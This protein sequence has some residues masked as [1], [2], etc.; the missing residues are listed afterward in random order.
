[1]GGVS[2]DRAADYYDATRA[3]PVDLQEELA[4]ILAAEL[5]GRGPCLEI[6]VG[7]GRIALPLHDRGLAL[8]GIDIAPA[9]L[10][11]LVTNAGDR[12]PFPL[13]LADATQLPLEGSSFGAVMA[14]HVLHLIPEWPLAVDEALRVLRPRGV[15]LV[16][17]GGGTRAPW[18]DSSE[19]LLRRH[20]VF[21]IRPG[22][23]APQDVAAQLRDQ[24][25][26]RPLRPLGM[27]V[28]RSLQQDLD[29]LEHQ[30]HAWTWPYDADQMRAACHDV[31][32]WAANQRWP[33]DREVELQRTI[34]W[35]AFEPK[36]R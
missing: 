17:F 1:M 6:G 10:A 33:L 20:G 7:T 3:L 19:E 36:S 21:H 9:M 31:V 25:T 29:E 11:R 35:W 14:S 5:A 16:D 2:F 12:R 30:I 23:S 8:L 24:A 26:V 27:T 13:L 34:Q 15:L 18:T 32:A 28:L 4:D 22:V